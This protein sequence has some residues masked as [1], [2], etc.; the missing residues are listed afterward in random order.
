[1]ILS[2]NI[3]ESLNM[4]DDFVEDIKNKIRFFQLPPELRQKFEEFL[5]KMGASTRKTVTVAFSQN[6]GLEMIEIDNLAGRITKYATRPLNYDAINRRMESYTEF[7]KAL[8]ELFEEFEISS[9]SNVILSLPNLL[10]GLMDVPQILHGDTVRNVILSEVEQSYIFKSNEPIVSWHNL[11]RGKRRSK[12]KPNSVLYTAIQKDVIENIL[13]ACSVVGCRFLTV[14]TSHL[15]VLRGLSFLGLISDQVKENMTWQLVIIDS[16]AFSIITM[17]G[18]TPIRY[19]EEPLA[20]KSFEE[21]EIYKSI[22]ASVTENLTAD[23]KIKFT[24]VMLLSLTDYVNAEALKMEFEI[25]QPIETLN[26]NKYSQEALYPTGFD[27][28]PEMADQI[29][30]TSIGASAFLFHNF[31]IYLNYI[32]ETVE[33]RENIDDQI[34]NIKVNLGNIE[35][36]ITRSTIRRL[37]IMIG[38]FT[39]IPL[40]LVFLI[41]GQI[42]LPK[43]QDK[44]NLLATN[45]EA[46]NKQ[47]K[48]LT[49]A[50]QQTHFDINTAA[51]KIVEVNKQ[52]LF[53][54]SVL[55]EIIPKSL[56]INHTENTPDKFLISGVST[57]T[58]KVYE[59]YKNLKLVTKNDKL[60]LNKLEVTNESLQNY[61]TDYGKL[62][63]ILYR[64]EIA[65]GKDVAQ[66][67]NIKQVFNFSALDPTALVEEPDN[68]GK[69]TV[70]A[71]PPPKAQGADAAPAPAAAPAAEQTVK[72][73]KL[74]ANLKR[75]MDIGE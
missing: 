20:L 38:S 17:Q 33:E 64:F 23:S 21:D 30:L 70:S 49:E 63:K 68:T 53:Q 16:N 60:N 9:N 22:A 56:W 5:S 15:S 42:V 67:E 73:P 10:F 27:V 44:A 75:I 72:N 50:G 12:D 32:K 54:Y 51:K 55:G 36:N 25:A 57:S 71:P 37:A 48:E 24:E 35:L 19:Y 28:E 11:T 4:F 61:I 59:F 18:Q 74:P 47:I 43:E 65:S 8:N 41:V 58:R 31:P 52:L 1:M 14:E 34:G 69:V 46:I 40:L 29:S 3:N 13:E 2:Y 39:I 45:I 26:S 6:L 7:A 66:E 62:P